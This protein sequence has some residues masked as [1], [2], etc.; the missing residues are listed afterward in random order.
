M[1]R[2]CLPYLGS[3]D[4]VNNVV[5]D[6]SKSRE[7]EEAAARHHGHNN[8]NNQNN[9]PS[10]FVSS[11]NS[12]HIFVRV[13]HAGGKVDHYPNA[14]LAAK[15]LQTLPGKWLTHPQVFKQPHQSII[16]PQEYLLP[17]HKYYVIPL[18]T[19]DKL[20][21]KHSNNNTAAIRFII[22]PNNTIGINQQINT[23]DSEANID[24]DGHTQESMDQEDFSFYSAREFYANKNKRSSSS[25]MNGSD[26]GS[27]KP[28][29]LVPLAKAK[30]KAKPKPKPCSAN[31]WEP[32]LTSIQELSP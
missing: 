20:M 4:C 5:N 27:R 31:A 7:L 32:G 8:N 29:N 25:A 21:K 22:P 24:H 30:P 10:S 13:V 18:S 12:K 17:G 23:A 3:P 15:I 19:I 28:R 16:Y 1:L 9:S 6:E 2:S 11:I 26:R 14:V